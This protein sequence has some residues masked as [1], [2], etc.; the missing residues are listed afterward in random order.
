MIYPQPIKHHMNQINSKLTDNI[1]MIKL[2]IIISLITCS[3]TLGEV[4]VQPSKY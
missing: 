2:A 3:F 4:F 1:V